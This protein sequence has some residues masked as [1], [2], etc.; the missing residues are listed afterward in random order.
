MKKGQQI[1]DDVHDKWEKVCQKCP[2]DPLVGGTG[3]K[4]LN[5]EYL[6]VTGHY[7]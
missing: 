7:L 5:S 3:I 2:Y 4:L 1:V 6:L